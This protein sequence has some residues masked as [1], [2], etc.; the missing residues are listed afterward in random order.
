VEVRELNLI[1]SYILP[2]YIFR[3]LQE[4][5]NWVGLTEQANHSATCGFTIFGAADVTIPL[6]LISFK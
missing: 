5:R 1:S 2:S 6:S 4:I 3:M